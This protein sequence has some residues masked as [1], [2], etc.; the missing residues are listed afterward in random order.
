MKVK[1]CGHCPMVQ[2]PSGQ[3]I[4]ICGHPDTWKHQLEQKYL[5]THE[6]MMQ[7]T[8]HPDCPLGKEPLLLELD[9]CIPQDTPIEIPNPKMTKCRKCGGEVDINETEYHDAYEY[10]CKKCYQQLLRGGR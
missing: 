4:E 6:Y 2:D 10:V 8:V 3:S 7:K 1:S 9:T 5:Y